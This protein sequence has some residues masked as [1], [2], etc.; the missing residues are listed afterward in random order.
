MWILYE[1]QSFE[2]RVLPMN[3]VH[4]S[5]EPSWTKKWTIFLYILHL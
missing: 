5:S 2:K 3:F 1:V 4:E